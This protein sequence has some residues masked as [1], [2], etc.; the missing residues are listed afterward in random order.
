MKIK[1][2]ILLTILFNCGIT[3]IAQHYEA[4]N[5]SNYAGSL[6][7]H[8]NPA[9]IVNTPY[10]WDLTPFGLQAQAA[11][12][13]I[14]I[15]NYSILSPASKSQYYIR[16]GE[17]ERK[18]A[19][20]ANINL[21]NARIAINQKKAFAFGANIRTHTRINT[22]TYY[23]IDTLLNVGEY[24]GKNLNNQPLSL[25]F[26]QS[27]WLEIYGSYAQTII[28]NDSMRLNAGA[29]IKLSRGLSG[30]QARLENGR[31]QPIYN[32]N[33]PVSFLVTNG[34][35]RYGYSSNCCDT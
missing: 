29:T 1:A 35:T 24:L 3:A 26:I 5:G 22:S 4:I 13:I 23:F 31:F 16:K 10:K 25:N 20:Q 12:N 8:N 30:A 2:L 11:T 18:G 9:S 21:M 14:R 27:G 32:P 6:G 17:F 34:D 15:E 33:N 28:D 19:A 7:V